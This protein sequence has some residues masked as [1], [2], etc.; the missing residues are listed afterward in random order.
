MYK[1][2]FFSRAFFNLDRCEVS[3]RDGTTMTDSRSGNGKNGGMDERG[4]G[5]LAEKREVTEVFI[6]AKSWEF[7]VFV[8]TGVALLEDHGER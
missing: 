5:S 4:N 8:V 6:Y 3:Q 7:W 1:N 2:K